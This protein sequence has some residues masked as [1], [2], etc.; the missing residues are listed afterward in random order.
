MLIAK[1]DKVSMFTNMTVFK[2]LKYSCLKICNFDD[3]KVIDWIYT[4]SKIIFQPESNNHQTIMGNKKQTVG[5]KS[6]QTNSCKDNEITK[7]N[8]IK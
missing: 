6:K 8:E 7:T 4:F 1:N 5:E 3:V 2:S